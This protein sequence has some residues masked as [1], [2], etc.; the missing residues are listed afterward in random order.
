MD[1]RLEDWENAAISAGNVSELGLT[2]GE[3]AEAA[4]DA[5][6]AVHYADR[7]GDA[8]QRRGKR[9]AH[10]DAL[11]QGGRRVESEALFREAERMQAEDRPG[12]PLL[13]SVRGFQ[14]CDL[15]LG[16]AE[17]AAWW[18]HLGSTSGGDA[19]SLAVSCHDASR[20][21]T[22]A[23][24]IAEGQNWLLDIALD[25]LTLGRAALY[26]AILE[27]SSS[28]TCRQ[29]IESA[30]EGLRR[31]GQ[32]LELPRG[33]LTRAWLRG[34]G[35]AKKGADGAQ[36][37]LDE[38]WEVAERGPMRLHMADVHLHRARLFFR[39]K[40]YPWR[41]PRE[42]LAAARKL[43]ESCGYWRRKE[44]LEDAEAAINGG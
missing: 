38:A 36:S 15:L 28:D 31:A 37:D 16:T 43:I 30:V 44:E 35:G 11:H 9:S 39:E 34:L 8:F 41:S 19:P 29:S 25:H 14:Y 32:S 12:H 24:E 26:T 40:Q 5:E 10:A 21:A 6:R 2:L 17:R 42:D 27:A 4:A 33:L 3:V 20:R 18:H 7:S 13:Y 1:V 23:L 22:Q